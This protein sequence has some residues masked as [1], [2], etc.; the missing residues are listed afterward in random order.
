MS[1]PQ[2]NQ[3]GH[4]SAVRLRPNNIHILANH[5][6]IKKTIHFKWEF[7]SQVEFHENFVFD[8]NIIDATILSI[9]WLESDIVNLILLF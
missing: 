2:P 8:P 6:E 7:N 3:V 4:G 9:E 1:E 5:A